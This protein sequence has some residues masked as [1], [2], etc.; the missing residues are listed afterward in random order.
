MHI[1]QFVKGTVKRLKRKRWLAEKFENGAAAELDIPQ[2]RR[3]LGIGQWLEISD[4]NCN[5]GE[6]RRAYP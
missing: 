1:C 5:D 4:R 6:E 2:Q 3:P